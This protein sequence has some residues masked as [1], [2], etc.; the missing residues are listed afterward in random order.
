[1]NSPTAFF[2]LKDDN[3][4]ENSEAGEY[5]QNKKIRLRVAPVARIIQVFIFRLLKLIV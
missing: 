4:P 1:L 3:K 5:A 2:D